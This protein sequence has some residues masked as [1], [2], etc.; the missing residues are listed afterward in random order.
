MVLYSSS[1]NL[2]TDAYPIFSTPI[3]VIKGNLPNNIIE[4]VEEYTTNNPCQRRTNKG[5]Y[6]T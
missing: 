6:Q 4:W 3:W 1:R 5:G 2:S